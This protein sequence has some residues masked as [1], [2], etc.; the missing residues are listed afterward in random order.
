MGS[1][2]LNGRAR[3]Q[4]SIHDTPEIRS[5]VRDHTGCSDSEIC[6]SAIALSWHGAMT[7]KLQDLKGFGLSAGDIELLSVRVLD[8]YRHHHATTGL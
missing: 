4:G 1:Q 7:P 2:R 6:F 5:R 8:V 3:S